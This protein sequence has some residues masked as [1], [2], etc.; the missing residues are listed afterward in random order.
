MQSYVVAAAAGEDVPGAV[1]LRRG[2]VAQADMRS[3]G[4]GRARLDTRVNIDRAGEICQSTTWNNIQPSPA[5]NTCPANLFLD[6]SRVPLPCTRAPLKHFVGSVSSEVNNNFLLG[7]L[8]VNEFRK[9][10]GVL[11][12]DF[13]VH[14]Q[15]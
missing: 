13:Q 8:D 9:V 3:V 5:R 12:L 15:L 4:D 1:R 10:L 7:H 11:L 6:S 14:T 2:D